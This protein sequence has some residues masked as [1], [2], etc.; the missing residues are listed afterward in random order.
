M[1][2]PSMAAGDSS[3]VTHK[4]G[5]RGESTSNRPRLTSWPSSSARVLGC[6]WRAR[7]HSSCRN[8]TRSLQASAYKIQATNSRNIDFSNTMSIQIVLLAFLSMWGEVVFCRVGALITF[9]TS[10][11]D[12][13]QHLAEAQHIVAAFIHTACTTNACPRKQC[14]T[15]WSVCCGCRHVWYVGSAEY[16]TLWYE[17]NMST[18]NQLCRQHVAMP[19][20]ALPTSVRVSCAYLS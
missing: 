11:G 4:E 1:H 9:R 18:S 3:V 5:R 12:L 8:F 10:I 6:R 15:T 20:T 19:H 16:S 2:R 17:P 13:H 7:P 14:C